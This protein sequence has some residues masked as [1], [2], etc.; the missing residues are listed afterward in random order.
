MPSCRK[1]SFVFD[2]IIDASNKGVPISCALKLRIVLQKLIKKFLAAKS[3]F[4]CSKTLIFK[5][6]NCNK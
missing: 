2:D 6:S 3:Y 1:C 4:L 5:A